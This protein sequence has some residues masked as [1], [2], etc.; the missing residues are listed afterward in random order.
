M[1]HPV[2]PTSLHCVKKVC[3]NIDFN[4]D[5]ILVEYGPVTAF[6][7]NISVEKMSPGSKLILIELN[8]DFAGHLKRT[9]S[10]PRVDRLQRACR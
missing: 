1:L 8:E 6:F 4:K 7:P 10:D 2:T 9:L 3:T 5:F